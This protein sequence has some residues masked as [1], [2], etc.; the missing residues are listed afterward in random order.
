MR[1]R[2]LSFSVVARILVIVHGRQAPDVG[3]WQAMIE[4]QKHL[5][6]L[7]ALVV[8][9]SRFPGLSAAQ[10]KAITDAWAE[11]GETPPSALV[12]TN[13]VHRAVVTALN[14]F[15]RRSMGSFP[16]HDALGAIHYV[17]VHE[18][19]TVE[20]ILERARELGR[21]LGSPRLLPASELERS[22]A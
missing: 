5:P 13:R 1:G 17:G 20:A 9:D 11:R 12:T 10:R 18:A 14:W 21:Q 16:P 8:V 19:A 4:A 15:L 22:S 3:E 2:T 6:F 7:G